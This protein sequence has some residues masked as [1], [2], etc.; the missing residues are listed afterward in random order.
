MNIFMT[1]RPEGLYMS[2]TPDYPYSG[3]PNQIVAREPGSFPD[4]PY[5][6]IW[7]D[8]VYAA[9]PRAIAMRAGII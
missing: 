5:A 4:M 7:F 6:E 2:N 3:N 9:M 8:G 1:I